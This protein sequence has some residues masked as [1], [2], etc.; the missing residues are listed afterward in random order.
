MYYFAIKDYNYYIEISDFRRFLTSRS[1]VT[2]LE[3]DRL[4]VDRDLLVTRFLEFS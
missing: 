2:D 3:V 1:K 4:E